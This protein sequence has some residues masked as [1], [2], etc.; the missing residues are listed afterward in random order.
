MRISYVHECAHT[1][2]SIAVNCNACELAN[3]K[4]LSKAHRKGWEQC[5]R[6]AVKAIKPS[7]YPNN[8]YVVATIFT[9]ADTIKAMTY[10]PESEEE[11]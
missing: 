8:R 2:C 1:R 11:K 9:C 4:E 6:E 7:C 3:Q 5:Q 10:T